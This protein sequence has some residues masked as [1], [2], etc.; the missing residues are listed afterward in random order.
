MNKQITELKNPAI[1]FL[2]NFVFAG[3]GTMY[4]GRKYHNA[5]IIQMIVT[6][7]FA[8]MIFVNPIVLIIWLPYVAFILIYG[9]K[10]TKEINDEI[11][12]ENL[13]VQNDVFKRED[14][15]RKKVKCN[16][17]IESIEKASKLYKNNLL[18]EDEFKNK[19]EKLIRDIK[20]NKIAEEPEDFLNCI[21]PL[22]EKNLITQ[23]ELME[24]KNSILGEN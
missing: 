13:T 21:I 11:N 22:K 2:L 10:V 14:V 20:L 1:T 23:D 4:V 16:D 5:G 15:E 3:A 24:I 7:I 9:F 19:K 17:F 8:I 18:S 6:L 12:E